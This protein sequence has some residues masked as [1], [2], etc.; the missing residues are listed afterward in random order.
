MGRPHV[1]NDRLGALYLCEVAVER[2]AAQEDR[3]VPDEPAQTR[4]R[5]ATRNGRPHPRPSEPPD[6]SMSPMRRGMA[7]RGTAQGQKLYTLVGMS[8]GM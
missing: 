5:S 6:G 4:E 7:A 1:S 2:G 3:Q 8:E